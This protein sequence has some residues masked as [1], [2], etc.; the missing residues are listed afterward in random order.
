MGL[1]VAIAAADS[2]LGRSLFLGN[3]VLYF[4]GWLLASEQV[5]TALAENPAVYV[6][7]HVVG[8]C[9]L[10][11]YAGLALVTRETAGE[12]G[13]DALYALFWLLLAATPLLGVLGL[14]LAVGALAG[15]AALTWKNQG[16]GNEWLVGTD[17]RP[18]LGRRRLPLLLYATGG[19]DQPAHGME[20][21]SDG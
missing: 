1:E 15:F 9:S 4:A 21:S 12:F 7:F 16:R 14:I 19:N 3:A 2:R 8:I 10:A 6:I 20:L 17:V 5:L 11:A 13:R 18:L